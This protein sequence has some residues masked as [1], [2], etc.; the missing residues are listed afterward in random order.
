MK[1]IYLIFI[2]I[3]LLTVSNSFS[4]QSF[5]KAPT[6]TSTTNVRAPNGTSAHAYMRGCF[7]VPASELNGIATV[8]ALNAIGFNLVSGCGT[9]PVNGTV[10]IYLENT[11]DPI[12]LKGTTWS[13]V[14][15]S[16]TSVYNN[17][18]VIPQTAGATTITLMLPSNFTY[19]GGGLYVAYDWYSPGPYETGP[20][21]ANYESQIN[22]VNGGASNNSASS[23]PAALTTTNFRP[24]F[25]F[26]YIN[27]FTNEISVQNVISHGKIPIAPS[28]PYS[29]GVIVKN[30]ASVA[31]TNATVNLA[32]SG[33]NTFTTTTTVASIPAGGTVLVNMP[34]FTPTAQGA[35]TITASVPS[36]QNNANNTGVANQ[37]V[38]CEML[39]LAQPSSAV[40]NY[41]VG[42]GFTSGGASILLRFTPVVNS[43]IVA[44]DLGIGS[45]PSNIGKSVFGL[46]ANNAGGYMASTNTLVLTAAHLNKFV[47]FFFANPIA[48]TGGVSYHAGLSQPVGGHF[49]YAVLPANYIPNNYYF[50]SGVLA[51]FLIS[52]TQNYGMFGFEPIF[53]NGINL[54]VTSSTICSGNSTTLT[55]NSSMANYTWSPVSSSASSIVVTPSVSTMYVVTSYSGSSCFA[56]KAGF[57]TVNITPTITVPNGGIC[58]SPGTYTFMP[59]GAASYTYSSGSN[60]VNPAVTT[61]YTVVGSSTAGCISNVVTPTVFVVA[62]QAALTVSINAPAAICLGQSATLTGVGAASYS[63]S[64]TQTINPIVVAPTVPNTYAV[65]GT[66]GSC[67]AFVQQLLNVNPNPTITTVSTNNVFCDGGSP[68][69]ITASGA[70]SYTWNT[71]AT[72][73]SIAVTPTSVVTYSVAGSD[74]NGC[75]GSKLVTI[76]NAPSPTVTGSTS[77]PTICINQSATLTATGGLSYVWAPNTS[78]TNIAI[79]SPTV[80]KTYTV[81]GY[82]INGCSSTYTILQVVDPCAGLKEIN[83]VVVKAVIYPNPNNGIFNISMS[84]ISENTTIEIYN[85]MGQLMLAQPIN[86]TIT[87]VNINQFSNGVYFAKIKQGTQVIET[88]RVIKN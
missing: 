83:G 86:A 18:M 84:V 15:S 87:T 72:T 38:T 30:M 56:K 46:L 35:S 88:M 79:V 27:T 58:P 33:A 2:I 61:V 10:Q 24:N 47:T 69:I 75:I 74:G 4:Q 52:F 16:M 54:S 41:S 32:M 20:T 85:T 6:G 81:T 45:D 76:G 37:S 39:A 50:Q 29:F 21:I 42:V 13:N 82:D 11:S 78:T 68:V 59:T 36:D 43:T 66:V 73:N 55:A 8:T 7:I 64:T 12:Y 23:A 5:Y 77:S 62:N 26:G 70:N 67:T 31:A 25:N 65:L 9:A 48:L 71:S 80:T 49:P 14:I 57:V 17:S 3:G 34:A 51:G 22:I 60:T 44:V 28:T 53:Q 19:T 63:W 1:K 40:N